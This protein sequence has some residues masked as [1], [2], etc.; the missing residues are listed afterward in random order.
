MDERL[1]QIARVRG[2]FTRAEV[3]DLGYDDRAIREMLR[4]KVIARVR[5]GAYCS[6]EIWAAG[7][8]EDRHLILARAVMR[9]H[10][11][12]VALSHTSA[13]LMQGVAVWN[14]DLTKVHVTRLDGGTGRVERDVV[15]HEGSLDDGDVTE[16]QGLTLTTGARAVLE[17]GSVLSTES[18]LVSADSA[19]HRALTTPEELSAYLARMTGWPFTQRLRL[20]V[21]L[22]DG[23]AESPGES[24]SRYLFWTQGLPAPDLQVEVRD[25]QGVLVAATDFGWRKHRVF[26]E[27]DGRVKYGRLLRPGQEPGD[28]VFEEKRREDRIRELTG[29]TVVRL[30]WD[31]LNRPAFTAARFARQ[32][33]VAA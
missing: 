7:S 31:D 13:L 17:A 2:V 24:R 4:A 9:A 12:R 27:F 11:G 29:F 3:L 23:R 8:A 5:H 21:R 6:R 25:E 26:G 10:A 28:A 30:T 20:V 15:H 33:G 32:L 19:L 22:S 18:G 14:A 1:R 16:R